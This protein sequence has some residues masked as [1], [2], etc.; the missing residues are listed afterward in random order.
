MG[1]LYIPNDR[2]ANRDHF[3]LFGAVCE[4][5]LVSY[6]YGLETASKMQC[7]LIQTLLWVLMQW[8][9]VYA[10]TVGG[11]YHV[12]TSPKNACQHGTTQH[13][14]F[15]QCKRVFCRAVP[16]RVVPCWPTLQKWA[17]TAPLFWQCK[18]KRAKVGRA[19]IKKLTS[20]NFVA[21]VLSRKPMWVSWSD[22]K[23]FKLVEIWWETC[24]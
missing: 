17:G 9:C 13:H 4:L 15:R 21:C 6:M 8:L 24:E 5:W 2:T 18:W 3:W 14:L 22:V 20:G 23:I 16:H 11:Y 10:C 1:I 12:Y 19:G 7:L